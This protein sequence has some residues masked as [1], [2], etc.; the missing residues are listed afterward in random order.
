MILRVVVGS[1][2]IVHGLV[3][4]LSGHEEVS[5][6]PVKAVLAGVV[7]PLFLRFAI[8][9]ALDWTRRLN[10]GREPFPAPN[11]YSVLKGVRFLDYM[12]WHMGATVAG[13]FFAAPFS[14]GHGVLWALMILAGVVGIRMGI[15]AGVRRIKPPGRA[16][17]AVGASA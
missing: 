5:I 11:P 15:R 1:I 14:G 12:T 10:P 2:G 4:G 17:R 16:R 13:V 3:L 8:P 9:L 6:A 7:G